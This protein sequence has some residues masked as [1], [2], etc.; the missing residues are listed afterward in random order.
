MRTVREPNT[1]VPLA[2][3]ADVLVC[4]GG[5]ATP[6]RPSLASPVPLQLL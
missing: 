4:G 2:G 1:E 6:W 3:E 5:P